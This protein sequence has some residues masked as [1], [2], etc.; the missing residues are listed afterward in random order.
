[1]SVANKLNVFLAGLSNVQQNLGAIGTFTGDQVAYIQQSLM[2]AN[3]YYGVPVSVWQRAFQFKTDGSIDVQQE[4]VT[5]YVHVAKDLIGTSSATPTAGNT[6]GL[7]QVDNTLTIL[8]DK[9]NAVYTSRKMTDFSASDA[10]PNDPAAA[11]SYLKLLAKGVFGSSQAV[12]MFSNEAELA[13]AYGEAI[14]SMALQSS[15]YFNTESSGYTTG[16]DL[17]TGTTPLC[18]EICQNIFSYMMSINEIK[19]RFD[20]AYKASVTTGTFTTGTD[21][22]VKLNGVAT[23]ATVDVFIDA[24]NN[25]NRMAVKTPTNANTFVKNDVVTI[26]KSGAVITITL[27]SV[28]AAMLNGKLNEPTDFPLEAGDTFHANYHVYNNPN[29]TTAANKFLNIN[30]SQRVQQNCDINI[31][32]L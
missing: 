5:L 17:T 19:A 2:D 13:V 14:E 16:P 7:Y 21:I 9:S 18:L 32:M 26:E 27:N 6:T 4:S 12:D 30:S 10:F 25:V 24:S 23:A 29:Q 20:M 1:M 8:S 15:N 3:L 28:Q 31:R 22:A 11:L